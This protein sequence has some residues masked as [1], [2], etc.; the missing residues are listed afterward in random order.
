MI[1]IDIKDKKILYQLDLDSRQTVTQIG[2][3]VGAK[4][5]NVSYRIKRLKDQGIIQNYYTVIDS[6][7]LNYTSFRIYLVF[8]RTTPKIEKEIINYF[9]KNKFT[10]LVCSLRGIYDHDV[11]VW[12]KE[13]NDF[14]SFWKKTLQKYH[15]YFQRQV[16]SIYNQSYTFRNSFLLQDENNII[17]RTKSEIVGGG[18]KVEIDDLDF[19]I[20]KI[21][22]PN[23][24]IPTVLIAKM[25]NST[26]ITIKN[27]IQK[28]IDL[29]VIQGF[30]VN[31]DFTKLGYHFYKAEV[32]L[33]DYKK[34]DEIIKYITMNSH[35]IMIDESI[36]IADLELDFIAK[37]VNHFHQIMQDLITKFPKV[38]QNYRYFNVIKI[39]KLQYLPDI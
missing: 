35:L 8:Q 30:R 19:Q 26:S 39:H 32:F 20:L 9:I 2:K 14:Y 24:R 11:I 18:K 13:I 29:N 5:D 31:I 12:V 22:A 34:R 4:K 38:I 17:D 36:G 33:D 21:L 27:R 25:L 10:W 3:K 1:N 37:N 23:S 28:L 16:V 7:K 6:S 15:D